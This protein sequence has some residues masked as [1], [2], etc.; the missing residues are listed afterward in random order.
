MWSALENSLM[1][2]S[3]TDPCLVTLQASPVP[4]LHKPVWHKMKTCFLASA[5]FQPGLHIILRKKASTSD[6]DR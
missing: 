1:A 2:L 3:E 6:T 5:S 4:L